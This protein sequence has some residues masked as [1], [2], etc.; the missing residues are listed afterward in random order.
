MLVM[1]FV[2]IMFGG[3]VLA[4]DE[5]NLDTDVNICTQEDFLAFQT[6]LIGIVNLE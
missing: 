2:G 1:L 4:Q 3:V 6:R 5:E